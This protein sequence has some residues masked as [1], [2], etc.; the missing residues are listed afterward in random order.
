[1]V[2]LVGGGSVINLPIKKTN[3]QTYAYPY[4]QKWQHQ[5]HFDRNGNALWLMPTCLIG[6]LAL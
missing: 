6:E 2:E 4:L 1:M 3:M 5:L